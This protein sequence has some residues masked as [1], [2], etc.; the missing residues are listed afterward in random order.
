[1]AIQQITGSETGTEFVGKLNNNF[2]QGSNVRPLRVK[3]ERGGLKSTGAMDYTR[4]SFNGYIRSS[5]LIKVN[6]ATK[7]VGKTLTGFTVYEYKVVSGAVVYNKVSNEG[8]TFHA[9]TRYIKITKQTNDIVQDALL[10]FDG[11]V[12]EVYNVQIEKSTSSGYMVSETLVFAIDENICTTGRLVLPDSYSISGKKVPLIIWNPCDGSWVNWD[13]PIDN[14][15]STPSSIKSSLQ[16]LTS[17]GFAV[18]GVH[19]WGSYNY[20]KFSQC[21]KGTAPVPVTLRVMEKAVEYVTTRF[22]ISD[23]NIFE[24]SWSGAGKLS[25][26]YA[27]HKAGFNLR[28][29][30]AFSP[31]VDGGVWML[32]EGLGLASGYRAAVN[33]EM[34]FEGTSTQINDYLNNTW[35]GI[36][37][38][39]DKK[40][41]ALAFRK[42][43]AEKFMK[44]LVVSSQ[45]LTG[46]YMRDGVLHN[47]D[48]DDK[49]EDSLN[50]GI[51]WREAT[52]YT[53][54]DGT[55]GTN[56]TPNDN[57]VTDPSAEGY[58]NWNNLRSMNGM[59]GVY[60]RLDLAIT[61]DGSPITIIGA[62]D[63][64]ACPYLA[65]EQFAV[66][67]RN[68]GAEAKII[69][70]PNGSNSNKNDVENSHKLTYG[71]RAPI[72]YNFVS[73]NGSMVPYGWWYMVQ[74]IKSRYLKQ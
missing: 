46:C 61:S 48:V 47:H 24:A 56:G 1:M 4:D 10:V 31:V 69:A 52:G 27:I 68:G 22:N 41:A 63:D 35:T 43:N 36:S 40:A 50:W 37:S 32:G 66:Q 34:K 6:D 49:L 60:N 42:L 30:Y 13:T 25:A 65:M 5:M 38:Y 23:T 21:G 28:H 12:E 15:G 20:T 14:V 11:D 62:K 26:Y 71:H 74:D 33:S 8:G 9:D 2:A 72:F 3:M 55:N 67:L 59:A 17:Q 29:I 39:D 18:L 58:V 64:A 70:L 57:P 54:S 53:K 45:N 7:V 19:P 51:A 44:Y 16:Y 73:V